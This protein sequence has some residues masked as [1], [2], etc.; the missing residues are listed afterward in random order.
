MYTV[1]DQFKGAAGVE[2]LASLACATFAGMERLAALNLN[3]ARTLL[4]RGV[5]T[6]RALLT[7]GD[8]AALLSAQGKLVKPDPAKAADYSRRVYEIASQTQDALS[9]I[10]Q[11]KRAA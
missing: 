10:V 3:T 7:A 11:G 6:S 1:S 8:A 2:T 5:D 9:K 4:A